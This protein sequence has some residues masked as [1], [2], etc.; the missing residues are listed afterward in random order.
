MNT[1]SFT[2]LTEENPQS[3]EILFILN[4]IG[5]I[6]QSVSISP[7]YKEDGRSEGKFIVTTNTGFQTPLQLFSGESSSVDYIVID[8][9]SEKPVLL[10]ESTQTTDKDSRNTAW[11]QR[12]TKFSVCKR[13]Y[14]N[15]PM[16][17]YYTDDMS[18]HSSGTAEFGM[19]IISTLGVEIY[20]SGGKLESSKF[21]TVEEIVT[22]KNALADKSPKHNVPVR[23]Q[24]SEKIIILS[25]RLNKTNGRMD[26][27]PNIGL[28]S[29]I[30]NAIHILD[31]SFTFKIINHGLDVT[32]IRNKNKFWF[33]VHGIDVN[34]DGFDGVCEVLPTTYYHTITKGEKMSTILFQHQ[35][36]LPAV[37]HNH[38]GCQR[39]TFTALDGTTSPVPKNVTMPDVVLVDTER[40][41]L[42]ITE[43]KDISKSEKAEQQL[44]N[45]SP[46]MEICLRSYPGYELKR[47]LCLYLD[48]PLKATRYPVWFSLGL[49]GV[50]TKTLST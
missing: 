43:G 9:T 30:I 48:K 27:D 28:F 34:I 39:S 15:V 19:R 13:M 17:M 46:F 36:G 25:G 42:Y 12:I 1:T 7:V 4:H 21:S 22:A 40:K 6:S 18:I 11:N 29:G 35:S 44:D 32:K 47:G 10:V 2:I 24:I 26:N 49:D 20:H 8:N 33:G 3:Q 38:A 23:L 37:F 14:P 45:L 16:V 50:C 5:I 31:P 41:T